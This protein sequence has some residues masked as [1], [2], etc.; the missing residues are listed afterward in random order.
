MRDPTALR[1]A[2]RPADRQL[3]LA[4]G[5]GLVATM[6]NKLDDGRPSLDLANLPALVGRL[7]LDHLPRVGS[8]ASWACERGTCNRYPRPPG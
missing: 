7:L 1:L 5:S 2:A 3:A 8:Q 4:Q 6:L